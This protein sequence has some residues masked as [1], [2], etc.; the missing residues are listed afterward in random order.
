[1]RKPD[2][3][4]YHKIPIIL[5]LHFAAAVA[6]YAEMFNGFS[7]SFILKTGGPSVYVRIDF[8]V[9]ASTCMMSRSKSV[10]QYTNLESF[11]KNHSISMSL[12]LHK[13]IF[14]IQVC[15]SE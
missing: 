13:I 9:E 2:S 4:G 1:M 15:V 5:M 8:P 7:S 12:P 11:G 14:V 3:L 10:C 6:P